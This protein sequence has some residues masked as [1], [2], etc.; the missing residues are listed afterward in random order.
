[1]TWPPLPAENEDPWY[2]KRTAFDLA[3]TDAIDDL[4]ARSGGEVRHDSNATYSY[5]GTAPHGT[6]EGS[7]GWAVT[8]ITLTSPPVVGTGTGTWT[9]RAGLTYS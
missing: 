8:R 4:I 2:E 1:M 6:A 5:M 3:V 7:S 9:G